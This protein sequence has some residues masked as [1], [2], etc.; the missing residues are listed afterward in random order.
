[1]KIQVGLPGNNHLPGS[2]E[3]MTGLEAPEHQR[4]AAVVDE[5][6]F[7]AITTSEHF[8]MP[9]WEVPR[10]GP[11]W[12]HALTVLAFVA[13][14]TRRVRVDASVLVLPYHHP[15]ALAKAI[16]TLD[17]LSGGR[18]DV[19]VGVGHAVAEFEALRVPFPDRG[20]IA[21]EMLDAMKE[22]W[23]AEEPVFRGRFFT[24]EGL[25]FEPKPVQR[26]R[27]PIYVGGNS[28]AALR[29]AARH[30][31]WQPNPTDFTVDEIPPLLDYIREQPEYR[32]KESTFELC[33]LGFPDPAVFSLDFKG[34]SAAQLGSQRDRLL[35]G[36]SALAAM[37]IT[38]T[39]V[40]LARTTSADE[41][42]DYLRW[43]A[44]EVLPSL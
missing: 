25:A 36:F 10:L 24:I 17:V 27:P 31:G 33:W 16:S 9:Y 3:W 32:G 30:E 8:A 26:P 12:T 29:R 18:V 21:D 15:L 41:Y 2:P 13:G 7:Y 42:L 38:R 11:Y 22:L 40:P 23:S 44:A 6:G 14:A 1:M 37:G 43:F 39:P 4:I 20:A 5:L 34:A 28:R 35:E 19:S